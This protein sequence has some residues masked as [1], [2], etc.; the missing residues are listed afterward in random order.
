MSLQFAL[1]FAYRHIGLKLSALQLLPPVLLTAKPAATKATAVTAARANIGCVWHF[2]QRY[3]GHDVLEV[4]LKWTYG[5]MT[6]L[7]GR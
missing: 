4:S 6:F 1:R 7:T 5:A 2:Q 3:A